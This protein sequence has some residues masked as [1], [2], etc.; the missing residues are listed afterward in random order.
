MTIARLGVFVFLLSLFGNRSALF[1][2]IFSEKLN[3]RTPHPSSSLKILSACLS[4][5]NLFSALGV[6]EPC[7]HQRAGSVFVASYV[8]YFSKF[9]RVWKSSASTTSLSHPLCEMY[10]V[11]SRAYTNVSP[12]MRYTSCL[13]VISKGELISICTGVSLT[14]TPWLFLLCWA[15]QV[16][17][18]LGQSRFTVAFPPNTV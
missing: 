4:I 2:S 9:P 12:S 11:S 7:L 17:F 15:S 13:Q 3:I 16:S 14:P 6:E 1:S 18:N 5:R 8:T 10:S